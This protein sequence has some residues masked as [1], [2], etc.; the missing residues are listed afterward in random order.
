MPAVDAEEQAWAVAA[1]KQSDS[2]VDGPPMPYEEF[3]AYII[4]R[5]ALKSG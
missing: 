2:G 1:I 3:C 4:C 5:A